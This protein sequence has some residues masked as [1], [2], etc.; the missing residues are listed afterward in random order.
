MHF[1]FFPPAV[2][3]VKLCSKRPGEEK[4]QTYA[5]LTSYFCVYTFH[6]KRKTSKAGRGIINANCTC[7]E[8]LWR[9]MSKHYKLAGTGLQ[10]H[11]SSDFLDFFDSLQRAEESVKEGL[12]KL[13][14]PRKLRNEK[15]RSTTAI[16]LKIK[17]FPCILH[18]PHRLKLSP[19]W[20]SH[21]PP[22]PFRDPYSGLTISPPP[23]PSFFLVD[24]Y[25]GV[26][27][28]DLQ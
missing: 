10:Y 28:T 25:S 2:F 13:T 20:L 24:P 6:Q 19:L 3:F 1:I 18:F 9:A 14:A 26:Y 27:S 8:P 16:G 15:A 7:H 21:L 11:F 4:K 12:V 17:F 22:P 5:L 23:P